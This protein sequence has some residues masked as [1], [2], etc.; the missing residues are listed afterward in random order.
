MFGVKLKIFSVCVFG[1]LLACCTSPT[2]SAKASS[3]AA[4][5]EEEKQLSQD[6]GVIPPEVVRCKNMRISQEV[7]TLTMSNANGEYF[8]SCNVKAA[9]CIT[10]EPGKN[11]LLFNKNTHW[12]MPG[13]KTFINLAFVQDWTVT[14]NN[15]ENIG[16]VP[17]DRSDGSGPG[18]FGM[19]MLDSWDNT[20]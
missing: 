18:A 5:P 10:P 13:A 2:K 6:D 12:K 19:Y 20:H 14:Y 9:G 8:L 7:K 4:A 11:Y 17:Q 15:A 1:V 16:L 3:Q